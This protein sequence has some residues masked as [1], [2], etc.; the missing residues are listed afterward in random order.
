MAVRNSLLEKFSGKFWRCWK[1]L[2][3][4]SSRPRLR[5]RSWIFS[6]ET[7]TT[8]LSFSERRDFAR[9]KNSTIGVVRAPSAIINFVFFFLCGRSLLNPISTQRFSQGFDT[10][11]IIAT[12]VRTTPIIEIS[13]PHKGPFGNLWNTDKGQAMKRWIFHTSSSRSSLSLHSFIAFIVA[14]PPCVNTPSLGTTSLL[15]ATKHKRALLSEKHKQPGLGTRKW[16][17]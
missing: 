4:F 8:F 16:T 9:G 2:D 14:R 12:C 15:G 5:E 13:P 10:K 6:S 17:C 11:L 7:A 3:Y 1:I